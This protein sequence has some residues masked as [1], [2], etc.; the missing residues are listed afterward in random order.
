D[1]YEVDNAADVLV[2]FFD[3]GV[4]TVRTTISRTLEAHVENGTAVGV[5]A[6]DLR[7]NHLANRLL[8]NDASNVLDGAA[9]ND[10]MSGLGGNDV[11]HV[12][13]IGDVIVEAVDGGRDRV[14]ATARGYAL[15]D[16]V[17]DLDLADGAILGHGNALANVIHGN[18]QN[19]YLLGGDGSDQLFDSAGDDVLNGGLGADIMSGGLNNDV[20]IVD[21]IADVVIEAEDEG[22]DVVIASTSV[23]LADNVESL[24]LSGNQAISGTGNSASNLLAGNDASNELNGGAGNDTLYGSSEVAQSSAYLEDIEAAVNQHLFDTANEPVIPLGNVGKIDGVDILRGGT[25]DDIYHVENARD[26]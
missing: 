1:L 14:I 6:I 22:Y 25:G 15:A 12:D 23:T 21:T 19:N 16:Q 20:Y 26:V 13:S 3:E 5:T 8:G 24:L 10:V 17:E 18:Q 2:E 11:Y 9:G 7:G 4:D